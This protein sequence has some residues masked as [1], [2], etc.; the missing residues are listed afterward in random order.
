MNSTVANELRTGVWHAYS[1]VAANPKAKHP[2][3]TGRELALNV[4]YPKTLLET[5]PATTVDAFAGVSYMPGFVEFTENSTV[6]DLGCGAGLDT[7]IASQSVGSEG[8]VVSIDFSATMLNRASSAAQT[9]AYDNVRFV[10]SA[11]EAIPLPA[12]SVDLVMINGIF[13]L[14]P[15]REIIFAELARVV[16]PGGAVYAAELI[17]RDPLAE[18]VQANKENWFA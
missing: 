18:E 17:L 10:R 3:P 6:L 11:A 15:A 8:S 16:R 4:G 2:F 1:N 13:N 7:L 12:A 14:N 9:M 5:L